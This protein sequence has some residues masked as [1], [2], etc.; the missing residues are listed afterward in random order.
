MSNETRDGGP[1]YPQ[2]E[3]WAIDNRRVT[4]IKHPGMSMRQN[5]ATALASNFCFG[6][7]YNM[8]D[9]QMRHA[10]KCCW[11]FADAM[12]GT[13]HEGAQPTDAP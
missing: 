11:R 1:V 7:V 2:S 3:G 13:E 6:D 5:Y 8:A 10:A 9:E 12:L 4:T